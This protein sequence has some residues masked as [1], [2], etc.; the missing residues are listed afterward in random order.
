MEKAVIS[1]SHNMFC[2]S[3]DLRPLRNILKHSKYKLHDSRRNCSSSCP[4]FEVACSMVSQ[5]HYY[6]VILQVGWQNCGPYSM[7]FIQKFNTPIEYVVDST[8]E[9]I[10]VCMF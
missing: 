7:N 10:I 2:Q 1:S 8:T 4:S 6:S 3:F 5:L 9:Y